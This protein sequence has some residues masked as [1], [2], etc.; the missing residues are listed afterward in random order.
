MN[1]QRL[2]KLAH[3]LYNLDESKFNLEQIVSKNNGK[4]NGA[5]I[6]DL[7]N[8]SCGTTACAVG[9][10]PRVFPDNAR[11]VD[12]VCGPNEVGIVMFNGDEGTE[13]LLSAARFFGISVEEAEYLFMP[14]QYPR[15]VR[16]AKD[17]ATR[18]EYCVRFGFPVKQ[19]CFPN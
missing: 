4:T 19:P 17:V 6:V 14:Q 10:C 1:S 18:I 12:A 11:W 13:W 7:Q 8:Q 2:L 5:K 3:F 9:W 16:G 15:N